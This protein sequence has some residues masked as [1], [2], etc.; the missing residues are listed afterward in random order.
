MRM[1]QTYTEFKRTKDNKRYAH[2]NDDKG[3]R[4][5]DEARMGARR[6]LCTWEQQH[7]TI[8]VEHCN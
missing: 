1:G 6:Y 2:K 8:T 5:A 3:R 7:L 4:T